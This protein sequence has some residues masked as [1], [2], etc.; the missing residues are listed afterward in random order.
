MTKEITINNNGNILK[1]IL[2]DESY[3]DFNTKEVTTNYNVSIQ[4]DI[5]EEK[6]NF[7]LYTGQ[8][9]QKAEEI[10]NHFKF[11]ML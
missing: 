6:G 4:A 9:R 2:T 7:I 1:A 5:N 3:Q 10:F 11:I 8:D